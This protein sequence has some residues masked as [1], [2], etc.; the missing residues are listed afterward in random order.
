[1]FCSLFFSVGESEY[2][3][4]C[5]KE[6]QHLFL[7]ECHEILCY[8]LCF[9]TIIYSFTMFATGI[10]HDSPY[11]DCWCA[12]VCQGSHRHSS[13]CTPPATQG[14]VPNDCWNSDSRRSWCRHMLKSFKID[15][16]C[17][18][19]PMFKSCLVSAARHAAWYQFAHNLHIVCL[20][21]GFH[22]AWPYG[23]LFTTSEAFVSIFQVGYAECSPL[24]SSVFD[25]WYTRQQ[26]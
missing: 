13:V 26:V 5:L 4:K 15:E 7:W 1:M 21:V 20:L 24:R 3:A 2:N 9:R 19:L 16:S 18:I 25:I 23:L 10:R 17:P 22:D 12:M 11:R 8:I 6:T 14:T